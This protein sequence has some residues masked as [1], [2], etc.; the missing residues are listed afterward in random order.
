MTERLVAISVGS[1]E[2]NETGEDAELRTLVRGI[3]DMGDACTDVKDDETGKKRSDGPD[4]GVPRQ[5]A[6]RR[7]YS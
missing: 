5:D 7:R 1:A 4:R 6:P 2:F 3:L